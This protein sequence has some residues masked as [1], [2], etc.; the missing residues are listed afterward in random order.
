MRGQIKSARELYRPAWEKACRDLQKLDPQ[1]VGWCSD[2][3]YQD[4]G[5][6]RGRFELSFLGQRYVIRYPDIA[7][8]EEETGQEPS[9][10]VQI[11]LLHYLIHADGTPPAGE[12]IAFRQLPGGMGYE[13]AHKRRA[14]IPLTRAFG[15]DREAFVQ[16]A[17]ALGGESLEFGDASFLFRILPRLWMAV[18]LH[19]GDEEFPPSVRVLYDAAADHY[20]PTEDLAILADLLRNRLIREAGKR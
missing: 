2:A 19:L 18:V 11:L 7:V 8:W 9:I 1:I 20:L 10:A 5:E 6:G 4:L 3:R 16:A 15:E 13:A 17:R 12:W 14:T